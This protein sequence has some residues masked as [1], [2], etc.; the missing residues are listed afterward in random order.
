MKILSIRFLNLNSLKGEHIIRFDE[1]PFTES[2]LFAITGPTG[3]GKTTI[4]D[5]ITVALYGQVHRHN[6]D[7]TE[8]MS[9][10]TAE[11]YAEVE[12]EVKEEIYRAKWS[13]RRA[14]GKVQGKIQTPKM[15]IALVSTGAF[16]GGHTLTSIQNAIIDLC[17]LDYNQ[18]LRSVILS[19]GDFTKFLKA[20]DNERSEL[21]EKITDSGIYSEISSFTFERAKEEKQKLETIRARLNDVPLLSSEERSAHDQELEITII[22]EKTVKQQQNLVIA[23]L[24]W[25]NN[26]SVLQE[27]T[28]Q[29]QRNLSE[30]EE[31]NQNY[32][33]QFLQLKE[34]DQAVTFLPDLTEIKTIQAQAEKLKTDINGLKVGFPFLETAFEQ[35]KQE[36]DDSILTAT[37]TQTDL[38]ELE[39]VLDKVIETDTTLVNIDFQVSRFKKIFDDE[40]EALSKLIE[41]SKEHTGSLQL[42]QEKLQNLQTWMKD[43]VADLNLE[44]TLVEFRQKAKEFQDISAAIELQ[45]TEEDKFLRSATTDAYFIESGNKNLEKLRE[46]LIETENLLKDLEIKLQANLAGRSLEDCELEADSMPSLISKYQEQYNLSGTFQQL[47]KNKT[48]LENEL[49]D[50]KILHEEN[51]SE[52]QKLNPELFAAEG[53][54]KNLRALVEIQQRIKNYETDRQELQPDQPCFLCGSLSHPYLEGNYGHELNAAVGKRDRQE[55]LV[56]ALSNTL[57][58]I[59]LRS[60]SLAFIIENTE[61]QLIK[62][63]AD[64]KF[65]GDEFAAINNLLSNQLDISNSSAI[66][67]IAES[68]KQQQAELIAK[69]GKIRSLKENINKGQNILAGKKE[70]LLDETGQMGIAAERLSLNREQLS[71]IASDIAGAEI[72]QA[73]V[74]SVISLLLVPYSLSFEGQ[75]VKQIA[76]DLDKRSAFYRD[77]VKN[78]QGLLATEIKLE[79]ELAGMAES[80]TGKKLDVSI[81]ETE[82][83][84]ETENY[85]S[86]K[87]QRFQLFA[88]KNPVLE[89]EKL[90]QALKSAVKQK[91]E[92]QAL[93]QK[94]HENLNFNI[95][96]ARQSEEALETIESKITE[97]TESLL[98]KLKVN[99][100]AS[101]IDL[102][103]LFL[104][105]ETAQQFRRIQKEIESGINMFMQQLLGNTEE[106][107]KEEARDL[108]QKPIE[109]L[110]VELKALELNSTELNREIGRLNQIIAEDERLKLTYSEIAEQI[111]I[112][113]DEYHRINKLSNVIGSADG[114]KFSRF[115]QGLTLARLTDLANRH[116]LKLTD[117]YEIL[118]SKAKDLELLIID[119]YQADAIRPMTTLSGGESFLVSL[120]L[121]LGLSDLA[122]RKVQ[123]N[124]LFIDEGFGTLDAD[125]LDVAISALE[126]LQSKG[127]TI[128]VISHVEALKERIGVQIQVSK[129]QGGHSKIKILSYADGLAGF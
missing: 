39:P 105:D 102:N 52:L 67:A 51:A 42:T 32:Q 4:L 104:S 116:L 22:R 43:H 80:I 122:S 74:N 35:A 13:V 120:A 57:K 101:I 82:W 64:L 89:R 62:V 15:E 94:R 47:S 128:G 36:R 9:R 112:Q 40:K 84:R 61:K 37:K 54:L 81:R 72:N 68:K 77:V 28:A 23:Q 59:T 65:A 124:S 126:N 53:Q 1:A 33:P 91:E 6:K 115:A 117:R 97:L 109:E 69:I 26:L 108:T 30:Q 100:I 83:N 41:Q 73:A 106:I 66:L 45:R 31:L 87:A 14:N 20:D 71:R 21:L 125:T 76:D 44:I 16:L 27:K 110:D 96:Q 48:E 46:E 95:S 2:G 12:F 10:H 25:K 29:Y 103:Q 127:K 114:K 118:K 63:Q 78:H 129:Q 79:T 88:D 107:K 121:A 7:A 98:F 90:N 11:S 99:G 92:N 8:M 24:N 119:K 49:K 34:H 70:K 55:E 50:N 60:H 18:F 75:R 113:K 5:A 93:L 3:A 111:E 19:Q 123:I 17:G 86:L 85:K 58:E 56:Q 38:S